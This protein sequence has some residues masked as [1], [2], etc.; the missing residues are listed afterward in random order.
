MR[1]CAYYLTIVALIARSIPAFAPPSEYEPGDYMP[2][3]VG[4]SWTFVHRWSDLHDRFGSLSQW[5]AYVEARNSA[6][7]ADQTAGTY[8][9]VTITVERAEEI[10]GDTYYVLS[11][12]PSAG[13]PPAPPHF[14]AG[15]KL[16]WDGTR[17]VEHTGAREQALYRFDGPDEEGYTIPTSE[18]D[19]RVAVRIL[20][21]QPSWPV[22]Y[23]QFDFQG[24]VWPRVPWIDGE[25]D[26]PF[27]W[28]TGRN[29][30]FLANYGPSWVFD[31]LFAPDYA[32]FENVLRGIRA[33]LTDGHGADGTSG[34]SS[35][36]V[37]TFEDA[38]YGRTTSVPSSSWGE[39]KQGR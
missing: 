35:T 24:Y 38:R 5:S 4:N 13:W 19:K 12:M 22:P 1:T 21:I 30:G 3:A 2:L 31:G 10:D 39:V 34:Q 14:V 9:T 36:R 26:E 11:G 25:E 16:R 17:L 37:V 29:V 33:T 6:G 23:Y 15:K 8:P 27:P 18:G 28:R 7:Q 20:H 32:V